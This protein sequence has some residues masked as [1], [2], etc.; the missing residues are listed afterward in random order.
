MRGKK[1]GERER[2]KKK[3]KVS[4]DTQGELNANVDL[5][6]HLDHLRELD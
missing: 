5:T 3:K 6:G 1:E 2:G 4:L